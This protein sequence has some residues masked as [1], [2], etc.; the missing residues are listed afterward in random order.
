[1]SIYSQMCEGASWTSCV[2]SMSISVKLLTQTFHANM[3]Y[4]VPN[5][6]RLPGF[7]IPCNFFVPNVSKL[8]MYH[9]GPQTILVILNHTYTLLILMLFRLFGLGKPFVHPA[10]S[11]VVECF[12][13]SEFGFSLLFC[14]NSFSLLHTEWLCS[15]S[16]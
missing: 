12:I 15:T 16:E 1:M 10:H 13:S 3:Q 11:E 2:L 9:N 7:V 5:L 4:P 6:S 14:V 8:E